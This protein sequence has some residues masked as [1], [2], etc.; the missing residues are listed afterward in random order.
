[1]PTPSPNEWTRIRIPI[2]RLDA[3]NVGAFRK[4]TNVELEAGKK[5]IVLDFSEV[6]FVDSSGLGAVVSLMKRLG[7]E[8]DIAVCNL[9]ENIRGMFRLTRLDRIFPIYDTW[10]AAL[11][12]MHPKK[13]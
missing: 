12:E 11:A 2:R 3:E 7:E 1:M 13:G 4:I 5:W 9:S 10:E 6:D 8:G